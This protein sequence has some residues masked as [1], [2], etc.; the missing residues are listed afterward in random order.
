[1]VLE[2]LKFPP[3][4]RREIISNIL[5]YPGQTIDFVHFVETMVER[6]LDPDQ[7]IQI[8]LLKD[9]KLRRFSMEAISALAAKSEGVALH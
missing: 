3:L 1:M 6:Y 8:D 2:L 9:L 5:S 4:L 7:T